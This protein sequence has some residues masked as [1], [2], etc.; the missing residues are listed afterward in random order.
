[1]SISPGVVV[2]VPR[3]VL[4]A[5]SEAGPPGGIAQSIL[6][7]LSL[8]AAPPGGI[9]GL[10][11]HAAFTVQGPASIAIT[12]S[13]GGGNTIQVS[14]PEA[15]GLNLAAAT[16]TVTL[17]GQGDTVVAQGAV[18]LTVTGGAGHN[19]VVGGAGPTTFALTGPG[20]W[21]EGGAGPTTFIEQAGSLQDD[22]ITG[23]HAGDVI[24]FQGFAPDAALL[25]LGGGRF[26]VVDGAG[27][28]ESFTL[29]GIAH[30]VAGT[31][32]LFV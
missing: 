32:Y 7:G 30:P 28:Q 31:D 20:D 8:P 9:A 4:P 18:A 19:H 14:A 2:S 17:S 13:A 3:I 1:M 27:R 24:R 25:D 21:L 23:F 5:W 15:P 26:A 12:G 29:D 22:R 16:V 10:S 11:G 6:A